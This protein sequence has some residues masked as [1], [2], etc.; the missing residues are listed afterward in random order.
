MYIVVVGNTGKRKYF[1]YVWTTDINKKKSLFLVRVPIGDVLGDVMIVLR[2]Y[3]L[4]F[5]FCAL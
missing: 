3:K 2:I 4:S 5:G 1:V